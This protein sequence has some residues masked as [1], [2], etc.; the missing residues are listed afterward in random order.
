M[1]AQRSL[2]VIKFL[3]PRPLT[4]A[5]TSKGTMTLLLQYRL[6]SVEQMKGLRIFFA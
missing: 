3:P 4:S 1:T 6:V 5:C 2:M